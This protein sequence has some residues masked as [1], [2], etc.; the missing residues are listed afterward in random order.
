MS[1]IT[2]TL[3]DQTEIEEKQRQPLLIT[4]MTQPKKENKQQQKGC[5]ISSQLIQIFSKKNQG[6]AGWLQD[7]CLYTECM[8]IN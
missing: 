7:L 4:G 3:K 6:W 1:N 5:Q 2:K 8:Q